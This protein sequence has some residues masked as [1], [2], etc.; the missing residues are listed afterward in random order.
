[1]TQRSQ[2]N[3][4]IVNPVISM[5]HDDQMTN[6]L[7][8]PRRLRPHKFTPRTQRLARGSCLAVGSCMRFVPAAG[9]S[10]AIFS[11]RPRPARNSPALVG[12]SYA[13]RV[14]CPEATWLAPSMRFTLVT[15]GHLEEF[16]PKNFCQLMEFTSRGLIALKSYK[17]PLIE[18]AGG[19]FLE[20]LR[21]CC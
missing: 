15:L 2:E 10:H 4:S 13:S 16:T 8:P 12:V 11:R 7:Q 1:M 20:V 18:R 3:T 14:L 19:L 6:P 5:A 21:S 9:V 17:Y